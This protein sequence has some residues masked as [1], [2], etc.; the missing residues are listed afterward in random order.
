MARSVLEAM[1]AGLVPIV[2]EETGATDIINDKNNGFVVNSRCIESLTNA[3]QFIS[4]NRNDIKPIGI[5]A[6]TSVQ[7]F[8]WEAYQARAAQLLNQLIGTPRQS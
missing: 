1:A 2:T 8:S 5:A 4:R 6:K 3:L 7:D